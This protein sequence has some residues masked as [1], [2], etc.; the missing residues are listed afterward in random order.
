MNSRTYDRF[1]PEPLGIDRRADADVVLVSVRGEVDM[2]SSPELLTAARHAISESAGR[3][4]VLD[5][6]GVDFLDSHGL[7]T[8][9][10]ATDAAQRSD[11]RLRVVVGPTQAARR[12]IQIAG[13]DRILVLCDTVADAR[14]FQEQN[15]QPA[16][17]HDG[18]DRG[19]HHEVR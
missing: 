15:V 9:V 1:A 14:S 8:L 13:L 12:P 4:V 10:T 2:L 18:P 17:G 19:H 11:T 6:T 7:A 5:L 16:G 3:V